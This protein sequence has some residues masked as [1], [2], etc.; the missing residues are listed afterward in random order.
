MNHKSICV[1]VALQRYLDFTP[2]ALRQRGLAAVLAR[3]FG[4]Q[5]TVVSVNAP[6]DLLPGVETTDDKLQRFIGPLG[7]EGFEVS[8]H[9][10]RGKPSREIEDFVVQQRAD[11]LIIGTHS[12]R[13]PLDVGL[14]STASALVRDV[15][16]A[17]LMVRPTVEEQ[18]EAHELMIPRYPL[19]FPYG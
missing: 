18:R 12:K 6:V 2:I 1:A 10:L 5:L 4:A 17:V 19:I 15:S 3:G 9:L 14:G 8:A 16:S 13:G 11:L 7:G